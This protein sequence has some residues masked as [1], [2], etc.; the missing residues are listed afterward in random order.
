M[1]AKSNK[2][3]VLDGYSTDDI[4]LLW[5]RGPQDSVDVDE[6]G[7]ELPTF[8]LASYTGSETTQTL[9]TGKILPLLLD[10]TP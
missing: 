7:R 10:D 3:F 6:S 1:L 4:K 5:L 2:F 8:Q 9:S